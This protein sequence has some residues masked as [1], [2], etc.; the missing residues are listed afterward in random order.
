MLT[1]YSNY[2]FFF[3]IKLKKEVEGKF[4]CIFLNLEISL[5]LNL[6]DFLLRIFFL[7]SSLTISTPVGSKHTYTFLYFLGIFD[8]T[9]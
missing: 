6:G 1:G 9:T 5:S 8:E 2:S 7:S 3:C 4:L